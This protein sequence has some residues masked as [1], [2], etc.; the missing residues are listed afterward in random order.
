[1]ELS[2]HG[3]QVNHH[4]PI[5]ISFFLIFL[6]FLFFEFNFPTVWILWWNFIDNISLEIE[7]IFQF[8]KPN[9]HIQFQ[10]ETKNIFIF[11]FHYI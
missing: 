6:L 11:I 5:Y 9:L 4:S 2:L 1:M 7:I 10:M 8:T 3:S